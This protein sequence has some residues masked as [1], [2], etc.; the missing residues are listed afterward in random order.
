M[1]WPLNIPKAQCLNVVYFCM[2]ADSVEAAVVAK[3]HKE[4]GIGETTVLVLIRK[5]VLIFVN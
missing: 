3:P 4:Y 1:V 2:H 5:L